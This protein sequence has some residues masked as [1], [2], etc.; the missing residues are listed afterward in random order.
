MDAENKLY[1]L[2]LSEEASLPTKGS[3]FAAGFDLYSAHSATI[4]PFSNALIQTDLSPTFPDGCYGRIAGRSGLALY[5]KIII[6]GG[7]VDPDFRGNVSVVLFNLGLEPFEI[8]R[9][10]RIAQMICEKYT[11]A[12]ICEVKCLS[13]TKRADRGFGSSN[14]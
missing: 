6:G 12:Q 1:V 10:D 13:D 14:Y 9:G 2:R 8:Q 5:N 11:P 3:D 4:P 7:V